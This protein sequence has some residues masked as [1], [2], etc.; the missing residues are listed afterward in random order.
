MMSISSNKQKT[1]AVRQPSV[2]RFGLSAVKNVGENLVKAIIEE[3]R[4]R[5]KFKNIEDFIIR[6]ESKDL[7]KKSLESLI[8]CGALDQFDQRERLLAN[9]D[10]L[11]N[12]KKNR[13]K[14]SLSGQTSLFGLLPKKETEE[15][16]LKLKLKD[17]P[18]LDKKTRLAWEKELLGLYVSEHPLKEKEFYLK[19]KATPIA[20]LDPKKI[21]NNYNHYF[22]IAGFITKIQ[23]VYTRN[24][25]PM[26]FVKVEDLT[27][28]IEVLVFPGLL[29]TTADLWQE[30]K[31]VLIKGR[32]S[33]RD[34]IPK[35]IA[36]EAKV[37]DIDNLEIKKLE[38][39]LP[40]SITQDK[41]EKLKKLL[42]VNPGKDK[43]YLI[44]D[45]NIRL[46]R[47]STN[48]SVQTNKDLIQEIE[49]IVGPHSVK[50]I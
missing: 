19:D 24:N 22:Q 36:N 25:E 34:E 26:L 28:S 42:E 45:D 17:G 5:G 15:G 39:T 33:E 32:L 1:V 23:R 16:G 9:I 13:R 49:K 46:H 14:S 27:G 29:K 3:R 10:Q 20:D 8:K 11:L 48:F 41:I 38:I 30:D 35:L 7:N 47:I 21:V 44:F 40:S 4:K 18:P 12:L 2:I 37:V 43:V 6:V 31:L 50:I